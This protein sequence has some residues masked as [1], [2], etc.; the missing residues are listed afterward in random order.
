MRGVEASR[1]AIA[2]EDARIVP[3]QAGPPVVIGPAYG[4]GVRVRSLDHQTAQEL[5]I[6]GGLEGMIVCA[7][8]TLPKIGLGGTPA[9]SGGRLAGPAGTWEECIGGW[10]SEL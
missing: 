5:A 7:Q 10:G 9:Q 3:N 2:A 8:I 4:P 1:G 6:D